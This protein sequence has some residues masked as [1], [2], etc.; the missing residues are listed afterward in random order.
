MKRQQLI[1][2]GKAGG[3]AVAGVALIATGIGLIDGG[4]MV[5]GGI[6]AGVG[7]VL[8]MVANYIGKG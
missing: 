3:A 7:A 2:A 1:E 5:V 6:L 8:I 4:D